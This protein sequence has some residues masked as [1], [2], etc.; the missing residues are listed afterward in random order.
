M[1][2]EAV[3]FGA[4]VVEGANGD[5]NVANAVTYYGNSATVYSAPTFPGPVV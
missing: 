4:A 3:C 2:G 5:D 1:A